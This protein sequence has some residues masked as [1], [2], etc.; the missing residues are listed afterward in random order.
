MDKRNHS[1]HADTEG[2]PTGYQVRLAA[3]RIGGL[4]FHILKIVSRKDLDSCGHVDI[5]RFFLERLSHLQKH[6]EK[7]C[8]QT[9]STG[10]DSILSFVHSHSSGADE[11]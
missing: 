8:R 10:E 5:V 2:S 11:R 6:Q 9:D 1:G 7:Q 3:A 4:P